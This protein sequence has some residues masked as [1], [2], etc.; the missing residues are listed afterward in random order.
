MTKAPKILVVDDEPDLEVL[1]RQRFRKQIRDDELRFEFAQNGVQ[2]LQKL[3]EHRDISMILS[4][5]NMPEMDGLTLL[6]KVAERNNPAL[7]SVIISA[8]GDM[9]NIRTAMNR[10]AFDFLTKPIDFGDLEL[11][12]RKTMQQLE[13]ISSS[14]MVRDEL[15]AVQRDLSTASRIQQSLLPKT[16]PPFPD[17]PEV[18]LFARMLTAKEVGGDFYDFYFVDD[19]RLAFAVGDVSGKGIPAAIYMAVCRTLLKAIAHQVAEPGEVLRR[20][21]SLLIP[22]SDAHTFVTVFYGVLNVRT[23]VVLYGSGGHNPPYVVRATG[24]VEQL[25]LCDGALLGKIMNVNFETKQLQLTPGDAMFLYTDGVSEAMDPDMN[26]YEESRLEAYLA[27]AAGS[28][29][30]SLVQGSIA[31]LKKHT[32]DALQSDDITVL[33]LRYA[34]ADGHP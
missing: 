19:D 21:N 9:E 13:V 3:E 5:I 18:D 1:I 11:T 22:E 17:R 24:A 26:M 23:G 10:G 8:Y 31:D 2:A 12:M 14:L 29:I 28:S 27:T 7:K 20:L 4:D 33:T 25:P 30:Q 34:G 15:V 6:E 32:R 16:F